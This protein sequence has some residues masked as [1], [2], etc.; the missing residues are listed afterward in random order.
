MKK[1]FS[2][3]IP[4]YKGSKTIVD[5]INELKKTLTKLNYEIVVVNDASP[6]D[7]HNKLIEIQKQN[8]NIIT[9]IKLSKNFGEY[10]AVMAGLNNCKGDFAII[11]D[12]DFQHHPN[13]VAKLAHHHINSDKDVIFTKFIKK[14]HSIFRNLMSKISNFTA[15][16]ILNLSYD[17]YLSS[18]KSIRR[19]II[20]IITQY[21]GDYAFIDGLIL[22]STEKIETIEVNH[23]ERVR[24]RS[25]YTFFK[26]ANH[27]LNLLTNFSILPLRIFFLF[28]LLAAIISFTF[29]IYIVIEKFI[30][31]QIPI[32]YSSLIGLLIFFSSIQILF[33]GL[34]GEYI[35]KILK[36][37]NKDHQYVIDLIIPN[38]NSQK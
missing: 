12:D 10:N 24:G 34:V 9:Y 13:E 32:G 16:Q 22:S 21:K 20:N 4:T 14:K 5:L 25:T 8:R 27:Y 7:S 19:N 3:I 15:K 38:Q 2:I 18:F 35:G 26:L 37:V 30:N 17:I 1:L 31:P 6:D 11:I 29:L 23:Y 28:G 33:L 36:L